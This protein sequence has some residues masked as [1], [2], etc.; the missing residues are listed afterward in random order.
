MT[1]EPPSALPRGQAT[2]RDPVAAS[3]SIGNCHEKRGS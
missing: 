2:W 1:L 3:G